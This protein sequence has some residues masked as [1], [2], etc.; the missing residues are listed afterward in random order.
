MARASRRNAVQ[1]T[2]GHIGA[3]RRRQEGG[4]APTERQVFTVTELTDLI[5]TAIQ[6]HLPPTVLVSGE[7]SNLSKPRSGHVY[8][9][10]KD[11]RA[12]INCALWKSQHAKLRF[13]LTDG[14]AVLVEGKVDVYGPRGQYQLYIDKIQPYGL[15]ELELAFRQLRAKLE[16]QGLFEAAHKKPIPLYPLSMAVVTS[17]SGAAIR[18]ILRTLGRRWPVGRVLI[19]PVQVQG[20]GAAEEIAAAVDDLNAQADRLGGI[21]VLILA[22]GGGSLEDLWAFNEEIVARAIYRSQIPTIT[23]IGHEIDVT[24]ADLVADRR[25]ATPTAAAEL[26]AP[27]LTEVMD[28]LRGSASRLGQLVRDQAR[29][30]ATRLEGLSRRGMFVHPIVLLGPFGQQLDDLS[31]QLHRLC[32]DRVH[33]AETRLTQLQIAL[34][35]I[36]PGILFHRAVG[37]VEQFCQRVRYEFRNLIRSRR[38]ALD[39]QDLLLSAYS[40]SKTL[41]ARR[42]D[43]AVL[44]SRL[45]GGERRHADISAE[46]LSHFEARLAGC[47][48]RKVL[49]RGFAITRRAEDDKILRSISMIDV[50]ETVTTELGDGKFSSTVDRVERKDGEQ[51]D[52]GK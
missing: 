29:S 51:S 7:I 21:D 23:G 36:S 28:E 45:A 48:Y 44:T 25:A 12:Q 40:P 26:V 6:V 34:S 30:Q 5:K 50:G 33:R 49:N 43:L 35:K 9:T 31:A 39:R 4:E 10:L 18:D 47:D 42:S 15:G 52:T 20:E 41:P 8:F 37:T 16:Q 1:L 32:R 38:D 11:E 19:Y 3:E 46:T 2:F 27:V 17:I 24:I 14:L 22:R 13:E